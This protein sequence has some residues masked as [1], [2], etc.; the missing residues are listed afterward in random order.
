[1]L[2]YPLAPAGGRQF[3]P[4]IPFPSELTPGRTYAVYLLRSI[5]SRTGRVQPRVVRVVAKLEAVYPGRK[6]QVVHE[7]FVLECTLPPDE[8]SPGHTCYLTRRL[9]EHPDWRVIELGDPDP[10]PKK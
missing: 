8:I 5:Q 10:L 6:D 9:G 1:M 4:E 3:L 7:F 2:T